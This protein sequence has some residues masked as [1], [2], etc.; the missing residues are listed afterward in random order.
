MRENARENVS[1]NEGKRERTRERKREP[2]NAR[3]IINCQDGDEPAS[4]GLIK[5]LTTV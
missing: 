5:H 1:E 2:E 4:S 3:E